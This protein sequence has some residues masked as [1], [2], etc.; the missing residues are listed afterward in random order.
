MNQPQATS[1]ARI[2]RRFGGQTALAN[3][4]GKRQSTIEHWAGTGRIPAQWHQPLMSLAR[5]KGIVLEPKDFVATAPNPI[6]PAEGKL[7]VLLVGL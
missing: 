6:A 5:E 7:G 3:L 4:L 2:I 1:A